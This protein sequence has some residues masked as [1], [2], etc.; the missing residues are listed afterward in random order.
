MDGKIGISMDKITGTGSN[1]YQGIWGG[2][3]PTGT[4]AGTITNAKTTS[5]V[6]FSFGV[7]GGGT[8]VYSYEMTTTQRIQTSS[9]V[10]WVGPKADIYIGM[11]DN[12]IVEE[13]VAV[14]MIPEEHFERMKLRTNGKIQLDGHKYDIKNG[15]VQVLATGTDA[16]GKKVYLISDEVFNYYAQFNSDFI[17]TGDYIENELIPN[18][19]KMRNERLLPK[20]TDENDAQA[21]ADRDSRNVYIS[22]VD[23]TNP[24]F[25][26]HA[27][28]ATDK[29][30]KYTIVRPK[31]VTSNI[32]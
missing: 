18:L 11:T 20:G 1:Y 26:Y 13:A 30:A 27:S 14:R 31:E 5:E 4:V 23:A 29:K 3:T 32:D 9:G 12:I 6:G 21:L 7:S 19:L 25:G 17:H 15:T 10:K 24:E 16:N 22:L 2:V 8:W 28:L